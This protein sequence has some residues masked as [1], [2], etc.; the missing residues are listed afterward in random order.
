MV[1]IQHGK[2]E[3]AEKEETY[4][5][6]LRKVEALSTTYIISCNQVVWDNYNPLF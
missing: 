2:K 5:S 1:H 6:V 3:V 4:K